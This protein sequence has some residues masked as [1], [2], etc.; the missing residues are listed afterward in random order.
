MTNNKQTI[1][2]Q[3]LLKRCASRL[4]N[5][6]NMY[7]INTMSW[8][9]TTKRLHKQSLLTTVDQT[10]NTNIA[11]R[12][13]ISAIFCCSKNNC[14]NNYVFYVTIKYVPHN[15]CDTKQNWVFLTY[16]KRNLLAHCDAWRNHQTKNNTIQYTIRSVIKLINI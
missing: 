16:C 7:K 6:Y 3:H 2:P 4:R 11:H 12:C 5:T 1:A 8:R 9:F 15:A 10:T 13:N 14:C